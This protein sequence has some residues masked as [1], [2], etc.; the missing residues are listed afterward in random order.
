M[1]N[2][3]IS[4]DVVVKNGTAIA[5]IREHIAKRADHHATIAKRAIESGIVQ[6]LIATNEQEVTCQNRAK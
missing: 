3:A 2:K 1:K 5:T 4:R 6:G